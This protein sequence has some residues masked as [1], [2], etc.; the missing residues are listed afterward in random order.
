M[1]SIASIQKCWPCVCVLVTHG[2][3]CTAPDQT[4]AAVTDT[5]PL[6]V[7]LGAKRMASRVVALCAVH[8]NYNRGTGSSAH[9]IQAVVGGKLCHTA[10]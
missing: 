10:H 8:I 3:P 2:S 6:K 9:D 7:E 1:L 4:H 5:L